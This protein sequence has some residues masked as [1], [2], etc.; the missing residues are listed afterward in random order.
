MHYMGGK[1]KTTNSADEEY[2]FA[3]DWLPLSS[4]GQKVFFPP[5]QKETCL[6]YTIYVSAFKCCCCLIWLTSFIAILTRGVSLTEK[7]L[8][9]QDSFK[10]VKSIRYNLIEYSFYLLSQLNCCNIHRYYSNRISVKSIE[11]NFKYLKLDI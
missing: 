9:P 6:L 5:L 3:W 4:S 1:E 11:N 2:N 10:W 8:H 7:S